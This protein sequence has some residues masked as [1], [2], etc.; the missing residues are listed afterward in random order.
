MVAVARPSPATARSAIPVASTPRACTPASRSRR[1]ASRSP[2]SS[3]P[4]PARSCSPAAPP[5]RS[6]RPPGAWARGRRRARTARRARRRRALRRASGVD[7]FA[8]AFG[9]S[10]TVVGVDR[11]GRVDP[12]ELARRGHR[13]HRARAPPVGQPRG[14]APS[15]RSPRSWPPAASGACSSTSTPPRPP[16]RCPSTSTRSGADLLSVSAHKFGGPPGI[17]RA[18]RAP[19]PAPRARC[20]SAATRSGPAAPG[21]RTCPRIVGLRRRVPTPSP[22]GALADRGA[23]HAAR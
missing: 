4:G 15:S 7:Q 17:G 19:R 12:D 9:G 11:V 23:A 14:R 13:R 16:A 20:S 10:V 1:P 18:A 22:S 3:A 6:P 5:R 2:P 21:S 8:E